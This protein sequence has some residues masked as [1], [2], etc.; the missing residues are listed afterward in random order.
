MVNLIIG[1]AVGFGLGVAAGFALGRRQ[2]G[3]VAASPAAAPASGPVTTPIL[4]S[5]LGG[6]SGAS[7]PAGQAK[8]DNRAAVLE[9]NLRVK[10]Q[11]DEAAVARAIA[12]EREKHP[13][14]PEVELIEAAI[15]RWERDN[16]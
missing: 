15:D 11:Y 8:V 4:D 14:L 9:Q 12:L 6:D 2:P 7:A 16:R 5:L 13:N 10:L 1:L 3:T